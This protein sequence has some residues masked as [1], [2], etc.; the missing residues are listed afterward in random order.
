MP[1][2]EKNLLSYKNLAQRCP[3]SISQVL[4]IQDIAIQFNLP[5]LPVLGQWGTDSFARHPHEIGL[6]IDINANNLSILL[7]FC[8][9]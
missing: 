7:D 4:V 9:K 1:D 2:F 8:K 3:G 5:R 6:A